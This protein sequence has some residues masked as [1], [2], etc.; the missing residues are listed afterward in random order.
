MTDKSKNTEAV[1]EATTQIT[2]LPVKN[3]TY[4]VHVDR[5]KGTLS[6]DAPEEVAQDI[7]SQVLAQP[8]L[9]NSYVINNIKVTFTPDKGK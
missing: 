6:F 9:K 8:E 5:L 7:L 4:T 2:T 1:A 3:V